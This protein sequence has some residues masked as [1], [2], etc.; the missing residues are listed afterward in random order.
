MRS[1]LSALPVLC[2]L[3]AGCSP[4]APPPE[5][6]EADPASVSPSLTIADGAVRGAY[7]DADETILAFKGIPYAAPPVGDLRWRLPAPPTPWQGELDATAMS[8]AC[9]QPP[10]PEDASFYAGEPVPENED[11][12]YLNVWTGASNAAEK[13]PVMVWIHGGGFVGGTAATP[14]YDGEQLARD[15]VVLVSINYRLGLQGFFAHPAL[16]AESPHGAS[17]N[18]GL[19]DQIAA[20][21][22][23]QNN[24]AA[25][26]GNP[27]NVTIFGESAGSISVCY[28][29][30]TP[31]AAGLFHKAIAQ[32]GG[33]FAPHKTLD[34]ANGVM[35]QAPGEIEGS[36]H[37]IGVGIAAALGV[38]GTGAE[39][40]Q[41]LRAR[42]AKEMIG[43]L[44]ESGAS[45]PWRSIFVDGHM[46]PDQ[47]R[48]LFESRRANQVDAIV[49][50][51]ADEGTTLYMNMPETDYDAW[52]AE[53]ASQFDEPHAAR[54]TAAYEDIAKSSTKTARQQ[55]LGDLTFNWEMR[56]WARIAEAAGTDA[57]LY[58]FSH[59]PPAGEYGRSLGAF[60]AAE[61]AYAFRNGG[62][63]FSAPGEWDET[64]HEVARIVSGYWV[65]FASTGS[66][67]GEGLPD[68]PVYR[69]A[70]DLALEITATPRAVAGLRKE[71]LDAYD[72]L[73]GG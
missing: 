32:S 43:A 35:P 59:A 14:L 38:E 26:G 2:L 28:L 4:P 36:G 63:A 25:F 40:L 66:P 3:A 52:A 55:M 53:V 67:N 12:L 69:A 45:A 71:R 34:D 64:D 70:E 39:A 30:A 5:A 61:I 18:Q 27:E 23:V 8:P 37:D 60:H 13:R 20:V 16:T 62:S 49:G 57:W 7:T 56:T 33:C 1:A 22:W 44:A 10:L 65:S 47:M 31:L 68:W 15:G 11:C 51:T 72:A 9:T 48:A 42:D 46:F 29:T 21:Q 73:L 24:I 19:H 6:P 50:A 41:A 54:L 17:G 58:Q